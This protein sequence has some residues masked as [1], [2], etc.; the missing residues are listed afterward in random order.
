MT[1]RGSFTAG[2][3]AT[4]EYFTHGD[5]ASPALTISPAFTGSAK[6]YVDR[7]GPALPDYH[8]IGV[9]LRGH[10]HG[11][12]CEYEGAAYCTQAQPPQ[13]GSY[14][15]FRMS[16][17]AADV[18]ETREH[19]GIERAA[20]M[21]HSMGMNVVTEYVSDFGV[22][23]IT[24]MF[25]YDQ[26]PKNLA[27]SAAEDASYPADLATYPMSSFLSLVQSFAEYDET[28]GYYNVPADLTT[29]LGGTSGNPVFD[30]AAPSGA[31]L[32]TEAAWKHW[33]AFA[34]PMNGKILS[35]LFWS[36]IT[37]DY[38][39]VYALIARSKMPVLVYG[40]K[41]SIVP[42]RAMEW[43]HQQLP[44][45]ELMLFDTDVGVHGAF[46]N[47]PPSGDE[48]MR[49]VRSFFDRRVHQK[50]SAV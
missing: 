19:L 50:S 31:F 24:G 20:I 22:D 45:S 32:L 37:S 43:V 36:T 17:L 44:G 48:F 3:G 42:W 5:P 38:T 33:Q 6:L 1:T 7:F 11:G 26:A 2:D 40:G 27:A 39:D 34:N 28:R 10:G 29:M 23:G 46:L 8:V 30:P 14:G 21:G 13:A 35:M 15:G 47:P 49:R 12:G 25:V 18:R 9:Q 4:V 16:R 41:S